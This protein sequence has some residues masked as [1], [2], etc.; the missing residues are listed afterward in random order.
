MDGSS[1]ASEENTYTGPMPRTISGNVIRRRTREKRYKY[2]SSRMRM[3]IQQKKSIFDI[4]PIDS[5]HEVDNERMLGQIASRQITQNFIEGIHQPV[6]QPI[7]ETRYNIDF[8]NRISRCLCLVPQI[9]I[10]FFLIWF[11]GQFASDVNW[12]IGENLQD[13]IHE[14]REC[15]KNYYQNRCEPDNR[16]PALN[17]L[18]TKWEQY[19]F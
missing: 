18:C 11:I 5:D 7:T 9:I 4:E 17:A 8:A 2:E 12:I 10:V 1:V 15:S 14:T 6:N 16:V 19:P 3:R 13:R